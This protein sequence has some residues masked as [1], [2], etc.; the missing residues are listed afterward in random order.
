MDQLALPR[1]AGGD[2]RQEER[3]GEERHVLTILI[4]SGSQE[5][6]RPSK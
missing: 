4:A 2:Q 3:P 5:Y 1:A 6:G